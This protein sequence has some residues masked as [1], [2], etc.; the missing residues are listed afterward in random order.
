MNATELS[1]FKFDW[2]NGDMISESN[3]VVRMLCPGRINLIGEHTDYNLGLSIACAIDYRMEVLLYAE[4]GDKIFSFKSMDGQP[5][6]QGTIEEL[7]N[8]SDW[9]KFIYGTLDLLKDRAD[10]PGLSGYSPILR[11]FLQR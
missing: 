2:E 9:G 6:V 4:S 7:K 10:L 3:K 1:N 8:A 5:M 11:Q